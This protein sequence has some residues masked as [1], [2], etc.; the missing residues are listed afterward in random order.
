MKN[1]FFFTI[2]PLV[3]SGKVV[4]TIMFD[5]DKGK[6]HLGCVIQI[7]KLMFFMLGYVVV[8]NT[9]KKIDY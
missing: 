8:E 4:Q 7:R 6:V 2:F 5:Y 1:Q 3:F 9:I